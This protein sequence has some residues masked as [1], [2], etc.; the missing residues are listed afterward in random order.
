[1]KHKDLVRCCFCILVL[2]GCF[3]VLGAGWSNARDVALELADGLFD[4]GSYQEAVTE[5]KRFIYF[6]PDNET[7]GEVYYRIGLAYR[8][9]GKWR[10][11]ADA[12]RKSISMTSGDSLRDERR[13]SVAVILLAGGNLSGAEFDLLRVA[14]FSD[15]PWLKKKAFFF[16]GVCYIYGYRWEESQKALARYF[17]DSPS[18]E[19][20][21]VDS[22]LARSSGLRYK[23][24]GVAKWLST[25]LPGSGQI[26]CGN[27]R[28]G[29]NALAVNSLTGYLL[30]DAALDQR[31]ADLSVSHFT[32]FY[33]YYRG[34]RHNAEKAALLKNEDLSR[35]L[36]KKIMDSLQ[37]D[38]QIR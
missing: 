23:S 36:A 30:V 28:N 34:N 6:N 17:S 13:I 38:C 2:V 32:L 3:L 35:T 8:N 16:L 19:G 4:M 27:W 20:H 29:I 37:Q 1:M 5:Y 24:P 12:V 14:N 25:F 15:Y 31:F 9:E 18:Q 10:E 7:N 33:R 21:Q 22:L 11:A 26:Y